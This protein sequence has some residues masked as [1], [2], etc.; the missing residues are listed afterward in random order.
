MALPSTLVEME[1]LSS[2][3]PLYSTLPDTNSIQFYMEDLLIKSYYYQ[4][5]V[6]LNQVTINDNLVASKYLG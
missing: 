6:N 3:P 1:N 4:A 2:R 5:Y